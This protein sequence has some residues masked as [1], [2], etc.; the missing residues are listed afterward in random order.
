MAMVDGTVMVLSCAS[1]HGH[2]VDTMVTPALPGTTIPLCRVEF[3]NFYIDTFAIM[4]FPCE[5]PLYF[6]IV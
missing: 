5:N 3:H 1:C 4:A 6:T 2:R